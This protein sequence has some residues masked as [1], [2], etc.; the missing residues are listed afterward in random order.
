M[1]IAAVYNILPTIEGVGFSVVG[2]NYEYSKNCKS[3]DD[4]SNKSPLVK[5]SIGI[6]GFVLAV[7]G[8]RTAGNSTGKAFLI[9]F[10]K[11]NCNYDKSSRNKKK[12][13]K[14]DLKNFHFSFLSYYFPP[15]ASKMHTGI[16]P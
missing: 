5:S 15:A 8:L 16:L 10:L 1:R 12:Y 14:Y 9:T 3:E 6:R 11:T 4:S 2:L 13:E 7:E